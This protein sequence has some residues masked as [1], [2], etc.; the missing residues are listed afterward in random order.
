MVRCDG[1]CMKLK[2]KGKSEPELKLNSNK[3]PF[4]SPFRRLLGPGLTVIIV[5][6]KL[7]IPLIGR[8]TTFI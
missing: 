3:F 6:S 1:M 7:T 2:G 5:I 4:R 8:K